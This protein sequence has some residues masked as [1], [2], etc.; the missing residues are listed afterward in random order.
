MN[1]NWLNIKHTI[2]LMGCLFFTTG[3]FGQT[4]VSD[5]LSLTA[6]AAQ[7]TLCA[8]EKKSKKV[9]KYQKRIKH[10]RTGWEKLIPTYNK[11]QY[12]G[13]MGQL[14]V[15]MGWDYGKRKQWE[16]DLLFGYV[17]TVENIKITMTL[18]QNFIPWRKHINSLFSYE[19]LECGMYLNTIFSDHFWTKEPD[20][21]P[22]GYY[23][24]STRIR[25][26]AFVGQRF[27]VNIPEN[28]RFFG[29]SVTAFYELSACD[30]YIVSAFTNHLNF[31][32]YMRLSFGLKFQIF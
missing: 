32:D 5:S 11:I 14:N 18:K 27:T 3:A 29:K 12:A 10:Y 17:P 26:H 23:G 15:G 19:P 24:F 30:L 9:I 22:S 25:I 13:G 8:N 4:A 1:M 16:T 6:E 7:D 21:Y 31:D 28:Y 20:R 2:A